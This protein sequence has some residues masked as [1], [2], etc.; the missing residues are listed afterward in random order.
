[1]PSKFLIFCI[2]NE[3]LQ[4]F[5]VIISI[6]FLEK[7][8]RYD[9]IGWYCTLDLILIE[10]TLNQNKHKK[11]RKT[12]NHVRLFWVDAVGLSISK[13]LHSNREV[14]ITDEALKISTF[15]WCSWKLSSEVFFLRYYLFYI[16]RYVVTVI[17]LSNLPQTRQEIILKCING[18]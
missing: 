6:L 13:I 17:R 10:F 9:T 5:Y 8:R 12:N 3:S 2:N 14:T 4:W 15:A 1:M 18:Y 7:N 16:L 11:Q